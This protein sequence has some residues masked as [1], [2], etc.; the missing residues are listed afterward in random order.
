[1]SRIRPVTAS[2]AGTPMVNIR[3]TLRTAI[4]LCKNVSLPVLFGSNGNSYAV[5][6]QS[7]CTHTHTRTHARTHSSQSMRRWYGKRKIKKK[8]E[9]Q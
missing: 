8:L 9:Q 5:C 7:Y 1:M 6:A 3:S 2:S 4:D